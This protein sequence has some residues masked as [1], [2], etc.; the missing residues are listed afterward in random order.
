MTRYTFHMGVSARTRDVMFEFRESIRKLLNHRHGMLITMGVLIT[1]LIYSL[2]RQF[3]E[4]HQGGHAYKSG[5]WLINYEG[6]YTGRGLFGQ[7]ALSVSDVLGVSILW[8]SFLMQAGLYLLFVLFSLDI[9]RRVE[10]SYLWVFALSPA[11]ILFG[12]LDTDGAFRKELL[13]FASLILIV[14]SLVSG[15]ALKTKFIF[16]VILFIVFTFSWETGAC[17]LPIFI[18]FFYELYY[19]KLV[20]QTTFL[21][22]TIGYSC[23]SVISAIGVYYFARYRTI[24]ISADICESLI[25]RGLN[26]TICEGTIASITEHS[27]DVEQILRH[28][29]VGSNYGYYVPI[30]LMTLIPFVISGWIQFHK[31]LSFILFC[32]TIPLYLLGEDYGRW[33][34]IFSVFLTLAWLTNSDHLHTVNGTPGR[35]K[36]D[37]FSKLKIY[38]FLLFVVMWRVPHSGEVTFYR[39]TF[40]FLARVLSWLH[41]WPDA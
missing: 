12:F 38:L 8:T 31:G 28:L 6:G 27:T 16:S 30:L 29:W 9:I 21:I 24:T 15:R 32:S 25:S 39:V 1:S 41:L 26:S 3:I 2:L 10:S 33:I 11:F 13:G 18:Y 14:H 7:L 34:H 35:V 23:V 5:D 22:L 4:V 40:G 20:S 37:E 36:E 19:R 17:F